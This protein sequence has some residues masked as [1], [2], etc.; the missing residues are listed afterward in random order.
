M[1]MLTDFLLLSLLLDDSS[2]RYVV[3]LIKARFGASLV[4]L[5]IASNIP[6]SVLQIRTALATSIL[7][8]SFRTHRDASQSRLVPPQLSF[9]GRTAWT[10]VLGE[11]WQERVLEEWA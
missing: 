8:L 6:I 7:T 11:D 9:R 10:F 5:H 1:I 3:T 4:V 2:E